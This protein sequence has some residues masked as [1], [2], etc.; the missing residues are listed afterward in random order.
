MCSLDILV[1]SAHDFTKFTSGDIRLVTPPLLLTP[2]HMKR[3]S[4]IRGGVSNFWSWVGTCDWG[5]SGRSPKKMLL[6]PPLMKRRSSIRGGVTNRI[7][8]DVHNYCAM[9]IIISP[10]YRTPSHSRRLPKHPHSTR[11]RPFSGVF[12][13]DFSG[14]RQI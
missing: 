4:S 3:R 6:T 14:V 9:F 11:H 13:F 7:S 8:P 1:F 5:H 12:F 10:Q 2:P